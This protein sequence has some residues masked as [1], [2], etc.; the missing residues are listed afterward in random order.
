MKGAEL[1]FCY[2]TPTKRSKA[3]QPV[4]T[5]RWGPQKRAGKKGRAGP[6]D[7]SRSLLE[8]ED[9]LSLEGQKDKQTN[10]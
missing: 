5:E 3:R 6:V 1:K 2:W 4:A 8:K 7:P 9:P 10:K